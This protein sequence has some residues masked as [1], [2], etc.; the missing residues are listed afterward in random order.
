MSSKEKTK[1]SK[2]LTYLL[3]HGAEKEG[4]TIGADGYIALDDVLKHRTIKNYNVGLQHVKLILAS[5]EK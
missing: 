1:V 4:L 3:R 2:A 5:C